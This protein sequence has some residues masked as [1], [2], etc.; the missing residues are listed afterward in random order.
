MRGGLPI[1]GWGRFPD[2]WSSWATPVLALIGHRKEEYV[3][4]RG[5]VSTNA[6][7]NCLWG[8]C[9]HWAQ[10]HVPEQVER[11]T[12]NRRPCL[13]PT[14]VPLRL[15]VCVILTLPWDS[16]IT[17]Y[18]FRVVALWWDCIFLMRVYSIYDAWMVTIMI[19]IWSLRFFRFMKRKER[20]ELGKSIS[21]FYIGDI[22][23][24]NN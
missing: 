16:V 22:R 8:C 13:C 4:G 14:P 17:S 7:K 12:T 19:G 15:P 20:I 5:C 2:A 11:K 1:K 24:C 21:F 18:R 6:Y 10:V 3:K 23:R 9:A